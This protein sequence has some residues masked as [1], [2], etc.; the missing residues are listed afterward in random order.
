MV[1]TNSRHAN[2]MEQEQHVVIPEFRPSFNTVDS[3]EVDLT[4]MTEIKV[5]T[6]GLT[7]LKWN[8]ITFRQPK[9]KAIAPSRAINFQTCSRISCPWPV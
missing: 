1:K 2:K 6:I 4:R 7:L 9:T 3:V 5:E 8:V